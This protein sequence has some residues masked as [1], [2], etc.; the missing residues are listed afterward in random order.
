MA[1]RI[2]NQQ[3]LKDV[4]EDFFNQSSVLREGHIRHKILAQWKELVG[5]HISKSTN[6]VWYQ[7]KKLFVYLNSSVLRNELTFHKQELK[8]KI[9][10]HFR[11]EY[12]QEI[13]LK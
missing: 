12:V 13:I 10:Q 8:D 3:S 6:D 11:A 2:S 4:I 5:D 9:N 7:D 1:K